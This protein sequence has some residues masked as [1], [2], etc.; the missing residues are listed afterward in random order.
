MHL[1]IYMFI[2]E[3][4]QKPTIMN[5]QDAFFCCF[6]LLHFDGKLH[7]FMNFV[8]VINEIICIFNGQ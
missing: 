4:D 3:I 6:T 5:R 1:K 2:N 7:V 8:L